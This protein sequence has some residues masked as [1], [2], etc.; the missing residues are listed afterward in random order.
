MKH[1]GRDGN[2]R[3]TIIECK[4]DSLLF[5]CSAVV[6]YGIALIFLLNNEAIGDDVGGVFTN[7][8]ANYLGEYHG[9]YHRVESLKQ[10]LDTIIFSY[11]NWGG[12]LLG[13]FISGLGFVS[14]TWCR[15]LMGSFFQV[16]NCILIIILAC[17]SRNEV[18]RHSVA[19]ILIYCV[20][21]WYRP[22]AYFNYMWTFLSFYE[23]SLFVS[24]LYIIIGRTYEGRP[25]I[26]EILIQV[27]G[28]IVGIS[29]EMFVGLTIVI[30]GFDWLRKVKDKQLRIKSIIHHL[31]LLIGTSICF[32]A[33]G[34]FIRFNSAHENSVRVIPIYERMVG[35]FMGHLNILFPQ[36]IFVKV[37]FLLFIAWALSCTLSLFKT[38]VIKEEIYGILN[39]TGV[40][41]I[42]GVASIVSWGIM[43]R[44]QAYGL[45]F[46]I[47][48]VFVVLITLTNNRTNSHSIIKSSLL[49]TLLVLFIIAFLTITEYPRVK[50]FVQT[51]QERKRLISQAVSEKE[52]EVIV[53]RYPNECKSERLN[54]DY[55]NN[56][57]FYDE[58][59]VD[60]YYGI[61]VIL[62]K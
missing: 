12:R 31:G 59:S 38:H 27:L 8:T 13:Y 51:S 62:D 32:M 18:V 30:I 49:E 21:Y 14:P 15:A 60:A 53:P 19:L 47:A 34:N 1:L 22:L 2:I 58:P 35:S 16:G 28:L 26:K 41:I 61:H 48:L 56:Q 52:G 39:K 11:N 20:M 36:N 25:A 24:L 29:H 55:L 10:F 37:V 46:W 23:A 7:A 54:F 50:M 3:G 9:E 17:D 6:L 44:T 45:S 40:Y 4:L 57:D 33:P 5:V 42:A 43:P